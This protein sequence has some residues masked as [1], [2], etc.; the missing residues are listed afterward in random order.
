M[1]PQAILTGIIQ[2]GLISSF[3]ISVPLLI[4]H[5]RFL[6]QGKKIGLLSYFA[7]VLGQSLFFLFLSS[8]SRQVLSL[9]YQCEPFL[10]L[11]G[12]AISLRILFSFYNEPDMRPYSQF[13][14]NRTTIQIFFLS[15]ILP[16]LN[17]V[18]IFFDSTSI[19]NYLLGTSG[20]SIIEILFLEISIFLGLIGVGSLLLCLWNWYLEMKFQPKQYLFRIFNSVVVILGLVLCLSSVL[21][22]SW[23]LFV[24]YPIEFLPQSQ[25]GTSFPSFGSSS[26]KSEKV[27]SVKSDQDVSEEETTL[28][29]LPT[30]YFNKNRRDR[31]K[32][33][34]ICQSFPVEKFKR[35]VLRQGKSINFLDEQQVELETKF[36]TSPL[37]EIKS[38]LGAFYLKQTTPAH[39]N[40][41]VLEELELN[42]LRE[43]WVSKNSFYKPKTNI[44]A[45]PNEQAGGSSMSPSPLDVLETSLSDDK[46]Q[47]TPTE[48]VKKGSFGKN[49][50]TLNFSYSQPSII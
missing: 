22:T 9:W 38:R 26:H 25:F 47:S 8:G 41:T 15:F 19:I 3:Q 5:R 2:I 14:P 11:I 27:N 10:F 37:N 45:N 46:K 1:I 24:I 40:L 33:R 44:V 18:G 20:P 42:L 32:V 21:N 49:T 39:L 23:R 12:I 29:L 31:E 34:L 50:P 17:P 30:K 43:T 36:N 48:R 6:F 4:C 28:D 35:L 13:G 7:T 16:I